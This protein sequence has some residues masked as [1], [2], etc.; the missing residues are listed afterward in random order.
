M[1]GF[2]GTR[3]PKEKTEIIERKTTTFHCRLFSVTEEGGDDS[4][5]DGDN[6][7]AQPP[8]AQPARVALLQIHARAYT[9]RLKQ[10]KC[11]CY[12]AV[13]V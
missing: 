9:A 12:Q 3:L 13:F 5:E 2:A 10:V 4:G 8:G 1:G 6:N 11:I 7:K